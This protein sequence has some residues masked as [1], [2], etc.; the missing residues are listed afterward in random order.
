M[1]RTI[2]EIYNA[3][4]TE[5]ETFAELNALT[6]IPETTQTL[7]SD[8]QSSSKVAIWR[9][10]FWV[11]AVAIWSHE[12]IFDLHVTE[13]EEL[14]L[15]K[16]F[17]QL[18]W[19]EQI[20]KSFQ[21]GY[22]LLWNAVNYRYEYIDTTSN[23]AII[24][25][26]I[27]QAAATEISTTV[28]KEII[29]KVAKGTVGSL[30]AL[31]SSEKTSFDYYIDR[32]KPAGTNITTISAIADDLKLSITVTYDPLIITVD[33]STP[34]RAVL[35]SDSAVY[36]V[37]EAVVDYIQQ[38]DFDSYFKVLDLVDAIQSV[39]GVLNVTVQKCS[40]RYGSLPYTDIMIDAQ[41]RY[42]ANAGYLSMASGHDVDEYFPDTYNVGLT[43]NAGDW[44]LYTGLYYEAK[45]D[46][47]TG[48][49]NGSLWDLLTT[50]DVATIKYIQG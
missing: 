32:I 8:L 31:T 41:Q 23:S 25:K 35:I 44:V 24:S 43:Y 6:P 15:N 49:W 47:I 14:I 33:G 46:G 19:Y 1:A 30:S 22:S 11:V 13:V 39:E 29:L 21:Y 50:S 26:I 45:E 12:K 17:G 40:A 34:E 16:T 36:P 10:W 37:E 28:G 4:I 2:S 27:T 38:I 9:L 42:N 48:V 20:S 18:K 5:K 3:I 7:L